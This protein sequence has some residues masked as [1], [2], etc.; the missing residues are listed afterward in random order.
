MSPR[1]CAWA[2]GSEVEVMTKQKRVR[3]ATMTGKGVVRTCLSIELSWYSS[4]CNTT[5]QVSQTGTITT[6]VGEKRRNKVISELPFRV[7]RKHDYLVP[8]PTRRPQKQQLTEQGCHIDFWSSAST[9]NPQPCEQTPL[10]GVWWQSV[11][12]AGSVICSCPD[13]APAIRWLVALL[14]TFSNFQHS[15][16]STPISSEYGT[17]GLVAMTSAQHA[18]GCQFDPGWVY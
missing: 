12:E 10:E 18:E 4:C 13:G 6:H 9:W 7:L 8:P 11:R 17:H 14:R 1:G 16:R 2:S 15:I 5:V 3:Q